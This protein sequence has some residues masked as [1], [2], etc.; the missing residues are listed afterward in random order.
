ML[1]LQGNRRKLTFKEAIRKHY[2]IYL[3]LLP[4]MI[5]FIVFAYVPYFGLQIAFKDFKIFQGMLA[6]PW[7]GFAHFRNFFNSPDFGRL[8]R[9]TLLISTYSLIFG[10]PIPIVFALLL[11]EVRHSIYKRFVQTVSYFPNFLSWVVYGGIIMAFVRPT[12]IINQVLNSFGMNSV[13]IITNPRTFRGFLV[14]TSVMKSFGF[15]AIIYLAALSH[16]DQELY[17]AAIVDGAKKLRLIRHITLPAMM[18]IIVTMFVLALGG[19]MNANFEQ[20]IILYNAAVFE[21]ADV[22]ETY[23]YRVGLQQAQYSIGA[24]VGLFKGVVG[25]VLIYIS[26][27]IIKKIGMY[28]LW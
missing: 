25:F 3:L 20:I 23:V 17:E 21:V 2:G 24:A 14:M 10:F 12:G 22:I 11:N 28:A 4:T 8:L 9:N 19:I 16:I 26:N 5:Y 1:D 15:S 18:P 6:S 13:N 7:V 27:Y